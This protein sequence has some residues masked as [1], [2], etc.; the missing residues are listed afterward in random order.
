MPRHDL[1]PRARESHLAGCPVRYRSQ[2]LVGRGEM[3][4][5]M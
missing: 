3:E 5:G 4:V 1:H 2:I